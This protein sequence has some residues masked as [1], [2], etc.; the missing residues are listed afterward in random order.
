MG[1]KGAVLY[2]RVSTVE[3]ANENNSLPL[4]R[5]K[6]A[7]FCER[8]SVPVLITFTD[9]GES[10]RTDDRPEFQKMLKYCK[11]NR[12]KISHLVVADLS[13][14]ARNVLDQGNTMVM[15]AELKIQ[16][17]SV[18]EPSL[19]ST[20]AGK[21]MQNVIGSMHQFFSDSLSEKTKGRMKAGV[22]KGRWL[23]IA[24]IGYLNHDKQIIVDPE[25][26]GL[27]VKAFEL[28]AS[29]RFTTVDIVR[30]QIAALGLKTKKGRPLTA[31]S[32]ARMLANPFY[33]GWVVSGGVRYQGVHTPLITE[34]LFQQVQ[35]QIKG[36][37]VPHIKENEDFS[38]RAFVKCAVCGKNVTAG[39]AKGR[40]ERYARYWC[41]TKG[42]YSVKISRKELELHFLRLLG[43]LEPTARF[44]ATLP[45]IARREWATRK[46]QIAK[47]AETLSKRMAGQKTLNQKAIVAKLNG[48]MTEEDFQVV[49]QSVAEE[50]SKI[51]FEI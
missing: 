37:S 3:Q 19:D 36:K 14:L 40:T 38:L 5:K 31:Q 15:L 7:G 41:W 22:E 45:D 25:R 27:V 6:T 13:R 39:W 47:D 24:P 21:L 44:L 10:A 51:E 42:C 48:Q 9:R 43:M 11:D 17:V 32:F 16:L 26:S 4:Q 34:N 33:I 35:D 28:V 46:V 8:N 12:S 18:D 30:R 50:I 20:A 2:L 23:W 29:R 1:A 49:K